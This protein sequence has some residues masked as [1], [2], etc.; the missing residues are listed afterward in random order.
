[1]IYM[2]LYSKNINSTKMVYYVLLRR[3]SEWLLACS[4]DMSWPHK[5]DRLSGTIFQGWFSPGDLC[6]HRHVQICQKSQRIGC[7]IPLCKLQGGISQPILR[8]FW[9]ICMCQARSF[10]KNLQYRTTTSMWYDLGLRCCFQKNL[11]QARAPS[12]SKG[13]CQSSEFEEN[14]RLWFVDASVW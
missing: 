13:S 5:H 8:L 9:H 6:H 3:R 14:V 2:T 10:F 12:K 11:R 4:L 1:M 7:V